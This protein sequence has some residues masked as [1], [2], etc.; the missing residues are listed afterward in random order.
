M[1]LDSITARFEFENIHADDCE[2]C[3]DELTGY[4]D[5]I[6][7]D[8]HI[9]GDFDE[10]QQ[11][12][13]AQIAAAQAEAS[14]IVEAIGTAAE[15]EDTRSQAAAFRAIAETQASAGDLAGAQATAL[16]IDEPSAQQEALL[17]VAVHT[18]IGT[19]IEEAHERLEL[20][21]SPEEKIRFILALS[22][23]YFPKR[24][25]LASLSARS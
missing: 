22:E 10:K 1:K 21:P 6:T 8:V 5:H 20:M 15:I 19:P 16:Q 14:E 24:R 18:A 3:D 25:H 11:K 23:K 12:R 2:N 7:S 9:S 17:E 13:L 4:I